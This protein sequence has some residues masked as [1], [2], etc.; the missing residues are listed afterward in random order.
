[1]VVTLIL[2]LVFSAALTVWF[3]LRERYATSALV[4]GVAMMTLSQFVIRIPLLRTV[5]SSAWLKS[6][7]SNTL[8]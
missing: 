2:S 7:A 1:M 8:S 4:V 5:S 3:Y 6:L